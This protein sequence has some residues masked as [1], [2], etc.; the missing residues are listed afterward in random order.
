MPF[1][2]DKFRIAIALTLACI[3]LWDCEY[4]GEEPKLV[5]SGSAKDESFVMVSDTTAL[6]AVHYYERYEWSSGADRENCTKMGMRLV[7]TRGTEHN[8]WEGLID[9]CSGLKIEPL[10]DSTVLFLGRN[11]NEWFE[12]YVWKIKENPILKKAKWVNGRLPISLHAAFMRIWKNGKFLF[13]YYDKFALLDTAANTI[14]QITKEEAG[15]P[16]GVEDAQYFGD[17]LMTLNFISENHCEFGIMRYQ[18]D[19]VAV[20]REDSCGYVHT[21]LQLNGWFVNRENFDQSNKSDCI[22]STDSNWQIS[23]KPV[24][25]YYVQYFKSLDRE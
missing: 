7:D 6:L 10:S 15:W 22:F 3:C 14:T 25:K 9:S 8:Y 23:E 21:R 12:Y 24:A 20:H 19:T 16:D 2:K 4:L 18:T 13:K 1:L 11:G 17:D 5:E